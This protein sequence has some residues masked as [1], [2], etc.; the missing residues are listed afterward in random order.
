MNNLLNELEIYTGAS[1]LKDVS[2]RQILAFLVAQKFA[3]PALR[4]YRAWR[5]AFFS[6]EEGREQ[7]P[8][9]RNS[10][11]V[12]DCRETERL[13]R[14]WRRTGRVQE[15]L[16]HFQQIVT[17]G[18]GLYSSETVAQAQRFLARYSCADVALE[19]R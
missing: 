1:D 10:L 13:M 19:T 11:I 4:I 3:Y 9:L 2:Y 18:L 14:N 12:D 16:E 17:N 5:T 6:T 7:L 15:L 8:A